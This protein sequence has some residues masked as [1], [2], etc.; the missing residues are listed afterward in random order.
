MHFVETLTAPRARVPGT[1]L[2]LV[3]VVPGLCRASVCEQP[4]KVSYVSAAV[5]DHERS[6][7]RDGNGNTAQQYQDF[8]ILRQGPGNLAFG[9]SHRYTTFDFAGI[10]PQTNAHLHTA[11]FPVHWQHGERRRNFRAGIAPTLSTS[12]N[13]LG[14]PQRYSGDIL[15]LAFALV[16]QRQFS[17]TAGARYGICGD[18]RFGRYRVY[19]SAVLEWQPHPDWQVDLGFPASRVT[20]RISDALSTGLRAAPDGSE[21]HVMD[22]GFDAESRFIYESYTIEWL[23]TLDTGA[24]LSLTA[25]FGRQLENEFEM[26]LQSGQRIAIDSEAVNRVSAE[27]RWRF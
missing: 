9:Y 23:V 10:E 12:S 16:W 18:D 22:R 8:N 13:V 24:H 17:A 19:P 4:A 7:L 2:L 21:W 5:V 14:H 1:A 25:G 20:Y 27:L 11:A 15:Q 26:T 6:A 3:L